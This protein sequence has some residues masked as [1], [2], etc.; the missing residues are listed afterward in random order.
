MILWLWQLEV[1]VYSDD[2]SR[3]S[4]GR[5]ETI[6]TTND[7]WFVLYVIES[8]LHIEVQWLTL[9][10]WFLS[11]IEYSDTLNS[12]WNSCKQ[13][14]NREWTIEVYSYHTNLLAL[15]H[16]VIDSLTSSFSCRTHQDNDVLS[17][18]STIVIEEVML[19][20]SD[21][22]EL[23]EIVFNNLWYVLICRVTCLTVCEE[24]LWVLCST[25][26]YWAFWCH[27]TIT[28]AL[29]ILFINQWTDVFLVKTLNLMI[30][31]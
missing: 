3:C 2:L 5:T 20:T 23:I 7:Q 14:L 31:V 6:T 27:C 18:L 25:T 4:I 17:I 1:V 22:C 13:V 9:C 19:T 11:T 10:T 30:L 21:L 26:Y 24:G 15:R 8:A 16:E 12:L 29:N 28:E